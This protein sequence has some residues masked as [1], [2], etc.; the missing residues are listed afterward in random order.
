MIFS[1]LSVLFLANES[2]PVPVPNLSGALTSI[3][4]FE[5][6]R[7]QGVVQGLSGEELR[8]ACREVDEDLVLCL[9]NED[10]ELRWWLSYGELAQL[11]L[12][13]EAAVAAVEAR[14]EQIQLEPR[15]VHEGTGR[16][17]IATHSGGAPESVLFRPDLLSVVGGAPAVAVPERGV[18]IVWNRGDAELDRIMAVGVREVYEAAS[19]PVSSKVLALVDSQ[20]RVWLQ[21]VEDL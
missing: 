11:G 2:I 9:R 15:T 21:A 17:W 13:F 16:Y 3:E 18:V 8:V 20:W 10:S 19:R 12:S 6:Y 4:L 7:E 14:A 1:V 5:R